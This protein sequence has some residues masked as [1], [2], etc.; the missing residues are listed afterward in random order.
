MESGMDVFYND[1]KI[2]KFLVENKTSA[3]KRLIF[4]GGNENQFNF[5]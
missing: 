4:V 3:S 1:L 5:Y 2:V